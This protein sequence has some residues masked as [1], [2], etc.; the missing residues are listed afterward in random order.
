MRLPRKTLNAYNS[1]IKRQGD[2]AEAAARKALVAWMMDNPDA[3]I[4]E[5]REFSIALMAEIGGTCG[6]AAG[7][8]AYA[9]R[10]LIAQAAGVDLPD[11]DY[12]YEPDAEYV[13]KTAR[14]QVEKLKS[15]DNEGFVDQIADASRYFAERGAN[16]TM[17]NL[18]KVDAKRFGKKVR[19]ARVPT[20]ATT[21]SY[22]C[23]LASRGFVYKSELSALNANHRHCDCRIVEGFEGMNVE[24]YD[25]DEYY[26]RWKHPEKYQETGDDSAPAFTSSQYDNVMRS[27][28]IDKVQYY[29]PDKWL[30]MP[31]IDEIVDMLGGGDLTAGSCS[32]LA[33][34]YFGNKAGFIVR[35][36]RDGMSREKFGQLGNIKLIS[37]F[38]GVST[39]TVMHKN[40]FT[41][42]HRV[43]ES[44]TEGKEYYF[45]VGSHASVVRRKDG[46]VEYLELQS[47]SDN[48]WHALNDHELKSRFGCRKTCTI[49]GIK[50]EQDAILID[51][52]SLIGSSEFSKILGYINTPEQDQR[53]GLG[54]HVK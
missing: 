42:A 5:T 11:F 32:S 37:E 41:A 40:G 21:C 35:D 12:L 45:T 33:F 48:G 34:A 43:L 53:K 30:S 2:T 29:D 50:I 38:D 39:V 1:A 9:L 4:A 19:F 22:C 17:A 24:G 25:P 28:Q 15:G 46:K 10:D 7:D 16:D 27:L 20:G 51:G 3:S 26:D 54:G 8:A 6:Q 52:D 23:M 49:A 44:I 31:T 47:A 36:F 18:G 13:E 14:Y